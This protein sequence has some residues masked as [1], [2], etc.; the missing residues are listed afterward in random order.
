M[1]FLMDLLWIV[2][3]FTVG[4]HYEVSLLVGFEGWGDDGVVSRLEFKPLTNLSHVGIGWTGHGT[5]VLEE[6]Q[7]QGPTVFIGELL[8]RR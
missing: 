4:P 6:V 2:G 8:I 3:P 1:P 5:V 7:I